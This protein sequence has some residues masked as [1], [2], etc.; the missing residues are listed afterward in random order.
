M[1]FVFDDVVSLWRLGEANACTVHAATEVIAQSLHA[2]L[3]TVWRDV[4]H[5]DANAS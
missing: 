1:R 3:V 2:P 5:L 4:V